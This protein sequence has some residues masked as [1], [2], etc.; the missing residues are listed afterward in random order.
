MTKKELNQA[1]N[2]AYS[3]ETLTKV[4][5]SIFDGFGLPG[6]A[7]V[8]VTSLQ[9]ASLIRWQA[10]RLDGEIDAQNFNEIGTIG[11]KKFNVCG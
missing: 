11:R 8:N 2:I 1:L 4:D 5:I 6:F 3:V 7:P 9:V 10:I